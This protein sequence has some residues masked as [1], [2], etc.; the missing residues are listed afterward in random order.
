MCPALSTVPEWRDREAA[1]GNLCEGHCR[2]PRDREIATSLSG[3]C[4]RRG[5]AS[6]QRPTGAPAVRASGGGLLRC[7]PPAPAHAA[8]PALAAPM[9][10]GAAS[11]TPGVFSVQGRHSPCGRSLTV[12]VGCGRPQGARRGELRASL[13]VTEL[14]RSRG[15]AQT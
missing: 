13:K 2:Q 12:P 7:P 3:R 10:S 1:S 9:A 15:P 5:A 4:D 8:L 14:M 6:R 11:L